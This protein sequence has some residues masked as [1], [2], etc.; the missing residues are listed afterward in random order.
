MSV[1]RGK[2]GKHDQ[3]G[4]GRGHRRDLHRQLAEQVAL[5][6]LAWALGEF[7]DALPKGAARAAGLPVSGFGLTMLVLAAAILTSLAPPPKAPPPMRVKA[8]RLPRGLHIGEA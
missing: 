1:A 6:L 8:M 4:R 3:V 5:V 7:D 2:H